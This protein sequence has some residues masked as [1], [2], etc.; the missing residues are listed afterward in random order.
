[1]A[2]NPP[3]PPFSKGGLGGFE[4]FW[5]I[6]NWCFKFIWDLRFVFWNFK[7]VL[8]KTGNH[9]VTVWFHWNSNPTY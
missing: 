6:L 5:V 4:L 9:G 8:D 2:N 1:M 3:L 7:P